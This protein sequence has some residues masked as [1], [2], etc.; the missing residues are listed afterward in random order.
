MLSPLGPALCKKG[1]ERKKESGV[2]LREAFYG[3][4]STIILFNTNHLPIF[5]ICLI[6][7]WFQWAQC[8]KQ[9]LFKG[10]PL[11]LWRY[12][13]ETD[14]PWTTGLSLSETYPQICFLK[15]VVAL[16]FYNMPFQWHHALP[17]TSYPYTKGVLYLDHTHLSPG[18]KQIIPS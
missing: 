3:F 10:T 11:S 15:Y 16:S 5:N 14:W 9:A 7:I 4:P 17:M 13:K 18:I 2:P 8:F 6:S 12:S 1:G